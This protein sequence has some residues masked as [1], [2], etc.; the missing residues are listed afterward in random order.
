LKQ[1]VPYAGNVHNLQW[2]RTEESR[3]FVN[4]VRKVNSRVDRDETTQGLYVVSAA[5]DAY[6]VSFNHEPG[7]ILDFLRKNLDKFRSSTVRK[8]DI[9]PQGD[10]ILDPPPGATVLAIYQR[11]IPVPRGA[12]ESNNAVQRDFFWM[13]S[14][15]RRDLANGKVAPSLAQR[16]TRFAFN[17]AIRGE[18]ELWKVNELRKAAFKA[19]KRGN[20][21]Y[22]TG[23]F[24]NQTSD[25]RRG[26]EGTM[27]AEVRF[28]GQNI[29]SFKGIGDTRAW[30][31]S[32][33]APNPPGGKF[34][35]KFAFELAENP[36]ETIAPHASKWGDVYL[37]GR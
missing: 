18:P 23:D 20:V 17:E 19:E 8:V 25:N 33:H 11:I 22:L 1:F 26:I 6:G 29:T 35:V 12:D 9:R 32:P 37:T 4:T 7:V 28:S 30:G 13:L 15:E 27:T 31:N 14:N 10:G 2:L 16:L 36:N 34:P 3:W 5:G 24:R 21:I